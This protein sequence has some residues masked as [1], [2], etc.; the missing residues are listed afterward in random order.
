MAGNRVRYDVLILGGG[1]A[2][3]SAAR[4]CAAEGRNV[5]MVE[6]LAFGGT[7]A[8]RGCDPKKML[9]RGAE[10]VEAAALM[11]GKGIRDEGLSVDWGALVAHKK[12]FTGSMPEKIVSSLEKAGVDLL[13]GTA[14][15]VGP[16]AIGAD[17]EK[18]E[19]DRFVIATGSVP[20]PMDLPGAEHLV[21]STTLMDMEE[22]PERLL[23]VGAGYISLEFAHMIA[24]TGRQVRMVEMSDRLLPPFDR[25]LADDLLARTRKAGIDVVLEADIDTIELEGEDFV[26]RDG[27]GAREWRADLVI[28]GAGR[29]PATET[30][31]LGAANV[32][33]D[34]G[35][36]AVNEFLQSTTNPAVYAAGDVAASAGKP[37]T[38]VAALEGRMAARNLLEGN[39]EKVDH[40]GIPSVVFTIPPLAAVGLLEEE[41][42]DQFDKVRV[43]D[44]ETGSWFSNLRIGEECGRI[45]VIIDER[46]DRI[47]GAHMLG[48][49]YD[50]LINV[51]ALAIKLGLTTAQLK[52]VSFAYPTHFSDLDAML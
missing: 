27:E 20:R 40:T 15:F 45:R 4:A 41:A 51:F 16:Q 43:V 11:R 36:I 13:R 39:V 49:G 12:S 32:Q 52:S 33:T 31:N 35:G 44:R 23:F 50:E 14:A 6:D 30:L 47:L 7:C 25:E 10:I 42:R 46:E 26:V 1:T 48:D 17:G 3:S 9:R 19:A 22:L 28:H 29:V 8:L 34:N 18:F 5:A 24:R 38:P 2:A 37:L 21:T